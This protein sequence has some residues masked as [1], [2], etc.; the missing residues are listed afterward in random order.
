MTRSDVISLSGK[1]RF[2]MYFLF[3][4]VTNKNRVL[5]AVEDMF[6]GEKKV[7]SSSVVP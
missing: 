1:E 3:A 5:K 2:M 6:E 4:M 7:Q